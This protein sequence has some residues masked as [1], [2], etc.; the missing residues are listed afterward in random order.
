MVYM[1]EKFGP[2]ANYYVTDT[3]FTMSKPYL[4][5][6]VALYKERLNI[7]YVCA[8]RANL[9]DEEVAGLLKESNCSR[10][11]FGI[12]SGIEEVRNELLTKNLLDKQIQKCLKHLKKV[13]LRSAGGVMIGLPDDTFERALESVDKAYEFGTDIIN[14]TMYQP[15]VGTPLSDYAVEKGYLDKNYVDWDPLQDK[16]TGVS[17]LNIKDIRRIENLS[18]LS[19]LFQLTRSK[20]LMR[21]LCR[22]PKNRFYMATMHLPRMMR[23]LKYEL[24]KESF[25]R[26]CAFF[27]TSLGRVLLKGQRAYNR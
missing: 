8:T 7:P 6:F 19:P 18:L 17:V 21:V 11:N 27:I 3:N 2:V 20:L 1:N 5:E 12:E 26:R 23:S 24:H 15:D 14:V 4:R 10:V 13:G 22:L 25:S 16:K 9:I